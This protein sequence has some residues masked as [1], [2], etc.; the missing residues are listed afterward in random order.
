MN[1]VIYT[2]VSTLDQKEKGYSLRDQEA[3]LREYCSQQ[4]IT[5][6]EHFQDNASGTKFERPQFQA[7]M[8]FIRRNKD[9][10]GILLF[11]KW[12]RFGR[13]LELSIRY[14]SEIR[15]LGVILLAIEQPTDS[16]VPENM[17]VEMFYQ[18]MP[19]V[20][21]MRRNKNTQAGVRRALKEGRWVNN[22]PIGYRNTRDHSNK[23]T[24]EFTEKAE[25]VR[26]AFNIYAR[27]NSSAEEVRRLMATRGLKISKSQFPR[28]LKNRAY[29]GEVPIPAYEAEKEHFGPGNHPAMIE[30]NLFNRVQY[31]IKR[32][33]RKKLVKYD[34]EI[35]F[36]LRG[37]LRCPQCGHSLTASKTHLRYAYYHCQKPCTSR[38]RIEIAHEK[39]LEELEKIM[40]PSEVLELYRLVAAD[41]F[42][43]NQAGYKKRRGTITEKMNA[44]KENRSQLVQK[45]SGGKIS[46]NDY[47]ELMS[48]YDNDKYELESLL[49]NL[50]LPEYSF[51]QYI[52]EGMSI[53][54]SIP[55]TY[56]SAPLEIKREIL[57]SIYP[58]NLELENGN[59]RTPILNE[60][61]SL[62][63]NNFNKIEK[64]KNL[65]AVASQNFSLTVARTGI[66]P[67][68]PP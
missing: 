8:S 29:L 37:H 2:R 10:V 48:K 63:T 32:T 62:I 19:Q 27:G 15:K 45:Y 57:S 39:L 36:P 14:Q 11:T 16:K 52:L 12:D 26:E 4:E 5:I 44:L 23:P 20:E 35:E 61:L 59:Y 9:K 68:Y 53:L 50:E 28:L 54:D 24:L 58:K 34:T 1:A 17:L 65:R 7:M 43:D 47:T 25:L 56:S 60:A 31:L 21:N 42:K 46:D 55:K 64:G 33:G 67:V 66:E 3:R 22:A 49:K 41:T 51:S 30:E 38:V 40:I 13:N 18:L 6:L